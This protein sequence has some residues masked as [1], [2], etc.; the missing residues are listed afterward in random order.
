MMLR[1][2]NLP[3]FDIVFSLSNLG[4]QN[5]IMKASLVLK[6]ISA[7]KL[8]RCLAYDM[9]LVISSAIQRF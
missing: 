5:T 7:S 8:E 9:E 4:G 3:F 2:A 6:M 1:V